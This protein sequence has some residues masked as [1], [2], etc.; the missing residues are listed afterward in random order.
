LDEDRKQDNAQRHDEG[1]PHPRIGRCAH[2]VGKREGESSRYAAPMMTPN[3]TLRVH[4]LP[5]LFA[6]VALGCGGNQP[7]PAPSPVAQPAPAATAPRA[8]PAAASGAALEY[9]AILAK[10]TNANSEDARQLVFNG[11]GVSLNA[12]KAKSTWSS[13][14]RML[15]QSQPQIEELMR[16]TAMSQ[17][18]F[19]EVTV[20]KSSSKLPPEVIALL[21]GVRNGGAVLG[22]DAARTFVAG[23]TAGA[24]RRAAAIAAMLRHV[25][26][27][28]LPKSSDFANNLLDQLKRIVPPMAAGVNGTKLTDADRAVLLAALGALSATDPCGSSDGDRAAPATLVALKA[29]LGG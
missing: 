1:E 19:A 5:A 23:D 8:A 22:A 2:A 20:D 13:F 15:E 25:A 11:M 12:S 17:C 14:A 18:T 6:L 27:S 16:V 28:G 3:R 10:F 24:A 29:S 26:A 9:P 7:E 21:Q 4:A